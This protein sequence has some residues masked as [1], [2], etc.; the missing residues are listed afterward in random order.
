MSSSACQTASI[1][2]YT[3]SCDA[4]RGAER[5]EKLGVVTVSQQADL[6]F[7][8]SFRREN[9]VRE[10]VEQLPE[11][12]RLGEAQIR[13]AGGDEPSGVMDVTGYPLPDSQIRGDFGDAKPAHAEALHAECAIVT[14][15]PGEMQLRQQRFALFVGTGL[16]TLCHADQYSVELRILLQRIV[17]ALG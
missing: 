7:A 1:A 17:D 2:G 6:R 11:N 3:I 8:S 10:V 13:L 9:L 16:L 14:E 4:W 5:A 12:G 15:L